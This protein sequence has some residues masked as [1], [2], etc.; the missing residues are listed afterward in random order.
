[1]ALALD[2]C[3]H[4]DLPAAV[5]DELLDM[6]SA[7]YEEDFRAEL[8]MLAGAVHVLGREGGRIISHAAWLTRWLQPA[9]QGLLRCAY[10][11]AV[12]TLPGHEGRGHASAVLRA[13]PPLLADYDIAALSP[14]DPAFY[15]RLGW[16][17]WRGPLLAR[18]D[19]GDTVCEDEEAMVL[20]L[21]RTPSLDLG[22]PLS[23][24]W[25]DGDVW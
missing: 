14:S 13:L 22:A 10:I 17:S 8:P 2:I 16:Q 4:A 19:A 12:A 23:I 21:P 9:G 24:E 5:Q 20:M 11:E 6:L 15:A 1:M 3:A 18:G 25:R 7:A